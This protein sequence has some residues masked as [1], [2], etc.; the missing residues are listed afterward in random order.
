M[1]PTAGKEGISV[2]FVRPQIWKEGSPP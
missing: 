2:A 1:P